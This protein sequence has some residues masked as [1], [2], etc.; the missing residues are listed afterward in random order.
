MAEAAERG[1]ADIDVAE[2]WAARGVVSRDLTLVA[3]RR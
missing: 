2:E 1:Q 3:K